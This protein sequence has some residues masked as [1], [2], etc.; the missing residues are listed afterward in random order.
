MWSF[1]RNEEER[2]E[3]QK[4]AWLRMST[5]EKYLASFLNDEL[6]KKG[7]SERIS[8]L[9]VNEKGGQSYFNHTHAGFWDDTEQ[10][11]RIVRPFLHAWGRQRFRLP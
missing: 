3:Q 9:F 10:A 1:Y 11:D 4:L 2:E 7:I 8:A 6:C 5:K